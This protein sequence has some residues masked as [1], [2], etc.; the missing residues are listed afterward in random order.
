MH[1][2]GSLDRD[3]KLLTRDQIFHL[4]H[5]LTAAVHG[6]I[7]VGDQ[8]QRIHPL[9]VDKDINT[10]HVRRLETFEVVIQ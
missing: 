9:A 6:V 1:T 4:L 7:T 10:H 8:C 2:N 5:Q 3:I